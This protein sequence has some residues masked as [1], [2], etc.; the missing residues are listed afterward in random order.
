MATVSPLAQA[1][2][3]VYGATSP[4]E[5]VAA[6]QQAVKAGDF[7]GAMPYISPAGRRELA[8]EV[9]PSLLFALAFADPNDPMPGGK[10]LPKAEL[11][12]KQKNYQAAVDVVRNA[13]KPFGLDTLIG[14]PAMAPEQTK[15]IEAAIDKADTVALIT[16]MFATMEKIGPMLGFTRSS[17]PKAPF[18]LGNVSGYSIKGD[19]ATAKTPTETLDFVRVDGRWY[20]TPPKPAGK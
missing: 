13:L 4:Q 2:K 1:S 5:V 6:V 15:V 20:I 8:V 14:K 3:P 10:P 18:D 12:K 17:K 9:V 19:R 16:S 7:V 11:D